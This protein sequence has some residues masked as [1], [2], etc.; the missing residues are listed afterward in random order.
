LGEE[1]SGHVKEV[2]VEL[3][4]HM[5]EEAVAELRQ[6]E[7]AG[8]DQWSPQ[9]NIG[10][11]VLIPEEYVADLNVRMALYRRLGG[12]SEDRDIQGFAAE[13]VDRFGPLPA[14]VEHLLEIV[15]IKGLC[16]R[17]GVAKVDAGPKGAV[18]SFRNDMFAN[19]AG[20]VA[21]ISSSPQDVK[22]RPDQK[23][24][25]RQEWPGEKARLKGTRRVLQLLE[26]IASE[27]APAKRA[28]A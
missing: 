27:G 23:L 7:R 26:E 21:F 3:Y 1:Q 8:E 25:F 4:Q 22:L 11:A 28:T 9:I 20:L 15:A 2:G 17:A 6:G 5:L 14:E 18:I 24:V 10:A 19:P 12:L 16:R 13:L